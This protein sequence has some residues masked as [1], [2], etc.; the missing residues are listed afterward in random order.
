MRLHR[1]KLANYRGVSEREIVFAPDG[2]TVVEGPNEAGKSSMIEALDL[3]FEAK[4]SSKTKQVRAV[5]PKGSDSAPSVEAEVESG[6]YRFVY[7][8]QWLKRPATTLDVLAPKR[9]QLTGEAAHERVRSMLASTVDLELWKA[10]RMLQTARGQAEVDGCPALLKA[11]DAAAGPVT[12]S[13]VETTLLARIE[14]EVRRY[15]TPGGRPTGELRAAQEQEADAL[16]KH[17]AA[18]AALES[19][20]ADAQLHDELSAQLEALQAQ[21]SETTGE[22]ARA[23][24]RW[25]AVRALEGQL[26]LG[27]ER[28]ALAEEQ[29]RAAAKE[30]A[31]RQR[32]VAERGE[33]AASLSGLVA[34]GER[35]AEGFALAARDMAAEHTARSERTRAE[36]SRLRE[37]SAQAALAAEAR[38]RATTA[39]A[40]AIDPHAVRRAQEAARKAELAQAQALAV[41]SAVDLDFHAPRRIEIDGEPFEAEAGAA[42]R[43]AV[44][45]PLSIVVPDVLT[46]RIAPGEQGEQAQSRLQQAQEAL[47][48][49]LRQAGARTVEEAE[50]RL[51]ERELLAGELERRTLAL[52][53]LLGSQ[54]QET[55]DAQVRALGAEVENTV[56]GHARAEEWLHGKLHE[57]REREET[58]EAELR[59]VEERL[60]QARAQEADDGLRQRSEGLE[61][62]AEQARDALVRLQAQVAAADLDAARLAARLAE[63][64]DEAIARRFDAVR[65]EA[66]R[67][68]GRLSVGA[69]AGHQEVF[70]AT[71]S[72]LAH[73]QEELARVSERARAA[74]LLWET[75]T[76]RREA[77]QARY[78]A[79][80]EQA[81]NELGSRVFGESFAVRLD[82]QLRVDSRTL[83]GT[84]VDFD[85]LSE[86]AKEQVGML[87]RLACAK[88]VDPVA[89]A[90]LVI[91]DALG[92]SDPRRLA[93]MRDV[94]AASTGQVIV[95]TCFP[96]RFAGV[97]TTVRL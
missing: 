27:K 90:P 34:H 40:G 59:R 31:E 67:T 11:L 7:T 97:G 48:E 86:G 63:Q 9:E 87:V 20:E 91:D 52:A 61:S 83:G 72:D 57:I 80:L 14:A 68:A 75:V 64:R 76:A 44:L 13:G 29:A 71:G 43:R 22:L 15:R 96:E 60:G 65:D 12:L 8:K 24:E 50:R 41:S 79:P 56:D 19:V 47:G 25:E 51:E 78:A 21:R 82:G 54:T 93:K 38:R 84:T 92:H 85:S 6:P 73:A 55:I 35:L 37:L 66:A 23:R 53:A 26:D 62:A 95:L 2:T 49:A 81:V 18:S 42:E 30:W 4:D 39:L 69:H 45:R 74:E 94:L 3:L 16:R 32:L 89:G 1:L 28:A 88:L 5:A 36:L 70:D 58:A 33:R 77:A 46:V 10:L 17:A